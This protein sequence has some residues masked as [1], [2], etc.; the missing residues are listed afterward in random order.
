MYFELGLIAFFLLI[1]LFVAF[2]LTAE[3]SVK[4]KH[5]YLGVF[6]RFIQKSAGRAFVVFFVITILTIPVTMSIGI[7][8]W[9][10]AVSIEIPPENPVP[11]VMT[12][13]LMFLVLSGMLPVMWGRFR[14]WRQTVR[15]AAEVR[16]R[17][18]T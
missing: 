1:F 16:V 9:M 5:K 6:A 10:D 4:Q 7:G 13:L 2:W 17:T 18:T 11:I 3:G 14:I 8:Y 15:A 12:L